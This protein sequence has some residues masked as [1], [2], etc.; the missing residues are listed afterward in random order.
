M[1]KGV[2]FRCQCAWPPQ[3]TINIATLPTSSKAL[4]PTYVFAHI[5]LGQ[6]YEQKGR[7]QEAVIELQKANALSPHSPPVMA[8]LA[9]IYA[10]AGR[11]VE[12]LKLV[13]DLKSQ[14]LKSYVSPFYF[15]LIYAGLSDRNQA[16]TWLD[17]SCDDRSNNAIFLNVAPRFDPLRSDPRFERV[18][19]RIG[20]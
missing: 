10:T 17:A 2:G 11:H 20:V 6:C 8:V 9:N 16:F 15:V 13:D 18:R 1:Q 4:V 5:I 12:A 3:L 7:Y 19:K 14:S